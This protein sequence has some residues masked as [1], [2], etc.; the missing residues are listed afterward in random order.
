MLQIVF[1]I[2]FERDKLLPMLSEF[3]FEIRPIYPTL[4]RHE[5]GSNTS[6]SFGLN[7]DNCALV[8]KYCFPLLSSYELLCNGQIP[9][10]GTTQGNNL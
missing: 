2:C 8:K 7:V 9:N 1:Y 3:F 10:P 5:T 4:F 6:F